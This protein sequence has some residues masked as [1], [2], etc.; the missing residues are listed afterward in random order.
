MK[1]SFM[2]PFAPKGQ[3]RPRNKTVFT[4]DGRAFSQTYKDPKQRVYDNK[5]D[6]LLHFVLQKK[7]IEP[8]TGPLMLGVRAYMPIPKNKSKRWKQD[9][10]CGLIR[11]E[12]KPDLD[13]LI[14]T[15]KDRMTGIFY[16]DDKQVVEYLPRTGRYYSSHPRWEI[17]L[18]TWPPEYDDPVEKWLAEGNNALCNS[19]IEALCILPDDQYVLIT[20]VLD[21]DEKA[22]LKK[23]NVIC[24][25]GIEGGQLANRTACRRIFDINIGDVMDMNQPTRK[26][27]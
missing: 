23:H 5:L 4:K 3:A 18:C 26:E 14:K 25:E 20:D 24:F 17:E 10:A 2:I 1:I 22:Y 6:A 7:P 15:I 19:I 16:H 11:P 27:C 13:N 12:T 8:L 21:N 9:A